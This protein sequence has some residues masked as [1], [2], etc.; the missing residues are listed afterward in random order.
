MAYDGMKWVRCD[1]SAAVE[2]EILEDHVFRYM[3]GQEPEFDIRD[4]LVFPHEV[5]NVSPVYEIRDGRYVHE[6]LSAA[7]EPVFELK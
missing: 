2:Y 4:D 3:L 5:E 7:T 6:Y 1:A